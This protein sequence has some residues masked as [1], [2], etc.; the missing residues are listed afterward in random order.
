[1]NPNMGLARLIQPRSNTATNALFAITFVVF[2]LIAEM[3]IEQQSGEFAA[4]TTT[5]ESLA[6][7]ALDRAT[8]S[9]PALGLRAL[10]RP[11]F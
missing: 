8:S 10:V 5:P 9:M 6:V 4:A 1:M 7:G 11:Y 2:A 3:A